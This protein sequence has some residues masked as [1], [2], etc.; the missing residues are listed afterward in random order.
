MMKSGRAGLAV[1]FVILV[2]NVL[3]IGLML[4]VLPLL[5]RQ[6]TGGA[7]SSASTIY[8]GLIA[9]YSLMQFLFGPALGAL[10]D[11]Y[12]R[13]PILLL[14]LFGLGIDYLLLAVAPNLWWIA[15][16]RLVGGVMS[17]SISTATAYIADVTPDDRRAQNFGLIGVAFGIG[18]VA[19]PL[20][21]GLL[22][23]LG[24]R[25]PFYA[26]AAACLVAVMVAY[27]LLPESLKP[28]NRRLFRL[29]EANPI[30]AFRVVARYPAVIALI[31]V[32]VMTNLG[33][34]MLESTW[35]LFTAYRFDWGAAQ[36]GISLAVVG[37][38]FGIS[39]GGLVRV[40][41]PWLG[42]KMTARLGLAVG[43]LGLAGLAV[44][45]TPTML[46]IIL[47]PYILGWGLVSPAIQAL[48]TRAVPASQQGILQGTMSSI[49]TA[50]GVVAPPI[51]ASVFGYFVSPAAPFQ[52]PGVGFALDSVMFVVA[53]ALTLRPSFIAVAEMAKAAP[54]GAG[55]PVEAE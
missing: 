26:A 39:Q 19:G 23:A 31:V 41:V 40:V 44:T 38:L 4:P 37:V 52:F 7:I 24:A 3:G 18:F 8:G 30:G 35:V 47:V 16:A 25:V 32:Y 14:S 50:T 33:E 10:S 53:L 36:V 20:I 6:M 29:A 45:D 34:R 15:A 49:M 22:G 46:Y 54:E 17:A 28:G 43:A 21:G 55:T 11:K 1:L 13:R 12:G 2:I 48:V 5:V 42:E 51:G 9:L 27:L